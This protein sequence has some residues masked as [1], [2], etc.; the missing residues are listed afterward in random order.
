MGSKSIFT[1]HSFFELLH[2]QHSRTETFSSLRVP[3]TVVIR[4][5]ALQAWYFTSKKSGG[6][7][8]KNREHLRSALI[9]AEF[10]KHGPEPGEVI[11][12]FT[13]QIEDEHSDAVVGMEVEYL[14]EQGLAE[15]LL[16]RHDR[17]TGL[18]QRFVQ[19]KGHHN[20]AVRC[21][22][23]PHVLV[24]EQRVCNSELYDCR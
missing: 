14:D 15:L 19:P 23:S 21:T 6:I 2:K 4:G 3:D 10:T 22:W 11:G 13:R 24:A 20:T 18:I 5:D 7:L 12:T 1:L 17:G 9:I 8:R 16:R